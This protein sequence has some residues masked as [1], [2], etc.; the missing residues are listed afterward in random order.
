ME[1]HKTLD[2][3]SYL[4]IKTNQIDS[5]VSYIKKNNIV[6]VLV[7][8]YEGFENDS[9]DFLKECTGIENIFLVDG[10]YDISGIKYLKNLKTAIIGPKPKVKI[11]LSEFKKIES[12]SLTYHKNWL[13]LFDCI[14]LKDLHLWKNPFEDLSEFV[15]LKD[16]KSLELIQGKTKSL[17][18]IEKLNLI[19]IEIHK[20][21]SLEDISISE[22]LV[23]LESFHLHDCKKVQNH[24]RIK[25]AINLISL[26]YANCGEMESI[27]FI[28][29]LS[30]LKEFRFPKTLVKDGDLSYLESVDVIMFNDKKHYSHKYKDLFLDRI[31]RGLMS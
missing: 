7:S 18:G 20:M 26:R 25:N 6:D 16:L 14:S 29:D 21:S 27:S 17:L 5:I 22:K 13:N 1:F 12:L 8:K 19:S 2:G 24:N 28:K 4:I 11:D 10:D 23:E 30:K 31:K 3:K 9:V 15:K